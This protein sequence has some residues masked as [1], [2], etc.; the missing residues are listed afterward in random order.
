MVTLETICAI[1]EGNQDAALYLYNS[2]IQYVKYLGKAFGVDPQYY[3]DF[4]QLAFI[5]VLDTAEVFNIQYSKGE[6][7]KSLWK[8]YILQYY[9]DFK[10]EQCYSI[11]VSRSTFTKIR[12]TIGLENSKLNYEPLT[13][14][15]IRHLSD[16][17]LN[18]ERY[19]INKIFWE[20]VERVLTVEEY[21]MIYMF[22]RMEYH[23]DY[24]GMKMGLD[25]NQ[26]YCLK[27]RAI[28]KLQKNRFI[29]LFAEEFYC[30]RGE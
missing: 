23:L 25:H 13:H 18:V 16:I 8:H 9:L 4:K 30:V 6:T 22:Y 1:K 3:D 17:Q 14:E 11:R 26:A 12:K 20:E 15:H 29:K 21:E 28:N 19:V 5:A 27:R 2:N 7:F 24:I 10:L